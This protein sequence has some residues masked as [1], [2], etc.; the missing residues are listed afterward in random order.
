MIVIACLMQTEKDIKAFAHRVFK[1]VDR[2][3]QF[4]FLER[5]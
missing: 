3:S 4:D 1:L 2:A 5:S